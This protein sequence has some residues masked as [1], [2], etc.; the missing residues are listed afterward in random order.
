MSGMFMHR[1]DRI[2]PGAPPETSAAADVEIVDERDKNQG[3]ASA[4]NAAGRRADTATLVPVGDAATEKDAITRR[5]EE[6]HRLL[7]SRKGSLSA[8]YK[9]NAEANDK[10]YDLN[11]KTI[12][13][14]DA[15]A[16]DHIAFEATMANVT[17]EHEAGDAIHAAA[18]ETARADCRTTWT[19]HAMIWL[20]PPGSS[21]TAGQPS[22][23]RAQNCATPSG[24]SATDVRLT[25]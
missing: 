25:K 14:L 1:E 24:R 9:K 7:N 19:V 4:N 3:M 8:T 12:Q 5:L 17:S 10:A 23:P 16:A 2:R 22:R 15:L 11:Q 6:L 13:V 20:R 21:P 18:A